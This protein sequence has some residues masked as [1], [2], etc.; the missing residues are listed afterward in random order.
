MIYGIGVDIVSIK[1]L[2]EVVERWGGRFLN[3]VYTPA[4]IAYCFERKDPY[5]YL[6]AR[7][8][9]KEAMIKALGE[10]GDIT[11][12]DIEIAHTDTGRPVINPG[13]ILKDWLER[14][15]IDR[16]HLS[17]S[18]ER[19]Y[20]IACVILEEEGIDIKTGSS[21]ERRPIG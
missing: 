2:R 1:R 7:F 16:I 14:I 18:H 5:P 3:R 9:T 21:K 10:R 19:D 20:S 15:G 12:K 6:S 13:S 11:F 8:A 17:L 4:E